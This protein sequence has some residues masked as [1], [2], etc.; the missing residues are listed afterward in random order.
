MAKRQLV[1]TVRLRRLA[2]ELRQLRE[3]AGMSREQVAD[4][5]GMNRAT[6]YRIEVAQAKPQGR[7][8]QAL[9][10]VYGVPEARRKELTA[11]LKSAHQ[12]GWLQNTD[13]LPTQYATLIGFE[14]EAVRMLNYE[15]LFVPGLLQTEDYARAAVVGS[16]PDMT[17]EEVES[18]VIARA[19]RQAHWKP[20]QSLGIVLDESV[21]RREVGGPAIMRAQLQ[22]LLSDSERPDVT[23]QAIP[24]FAGAH[25]GMHGSFVILQF[26]NEDHEI[27]Y[28]EGFTN[29]LFLESKNDVYSYRRQFE[30]LCEQAA[31]PEATRDLIASVLA[32]LK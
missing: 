28:I 13:E 1:P 17:P 3:R 23:V 27:V 10:D 15:S 26:A 32:D 5:T 12:Q 6:L 20:P 24:Y 19:E 8:F 29:D 16:A 25:P 18:R 31:T 30:H 2:L 7:T 14:S 22:R 21:L 9:L 4:A 11:I